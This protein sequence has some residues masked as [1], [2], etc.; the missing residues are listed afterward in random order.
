MEIDELNQKITQKIDSLTPGDINETYTALC[1]KSLCELGSFSDLEKRTAIKNSISTISIEDL[2][3]IAPLAIKTIIQEFAD[4]SGQYYDDEENQEAE[5]IV[6][7]GVDENKEDLVKEAIVISTQRLNDRSEIPRDLQKRLSYILSKL[8]VRYKISKREIVKLIN[9]HPGTVSKYISECLTSQPDLA[10]AWSQS[11]ESKSISRIENTMARQTADRSIAI[12]K[13]S[14]S[15]ADE[16]REKHWIEASQ[17]GYNLNLPGDLKKL[18]NKSVQLYLNIDNVYTSI[19]ALEGE[20]ERLRQKVG[21][22]V[23]ENEDLHGAVTL[24]I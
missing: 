20:N 1:E 19:I 4:S 9:L 2:E 11:A 17:H 21:Y 18:I 10:K 22:L 3:S 14:I 12:I 15:I 24:L 7:A 5:T 8:N 23:E 16:I 6:R 13:D